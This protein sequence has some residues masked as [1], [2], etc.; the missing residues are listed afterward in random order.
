MLPHLRQRRRVVAV[1]RLLQWR[2]HL[3]RLR[4]QLK[5]ADVVVAVQ[6]IRPQPPQ[7]QRPSLLQM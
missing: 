7:N 1:A 4:L 2:P 3:Q 5:Q 6:R